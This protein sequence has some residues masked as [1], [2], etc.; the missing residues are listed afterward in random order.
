MPR[1]TSLAR[2]LSVAS[3]LGTAALVVTLLTVPVASAAPTD[4]VDHHGKGTILVSFRRGAPATAMA[5]ARAA[6]RGRVVRDV[7][8]IRA[9]SIEVDDV[10]AALAAYRERPDVEWVGREGEVHALDHVS[11][12]RYPQQ[13]NLQDVSGSNPGGLNWHAAFKS[14]PSLGAGVTVAVVDTGV[15]LVQRAAV[16]GQVV[17]TR[18]TPPDGF[19]SRKLPGYDVL[20]PSTPPDDENGHG[21]HIA[22]TIAQETGNA[23]SVGG[24]SM[25]GVAPSARILPIRVLNQEGSGSPAAAADGI[26]RAVDL[27]AKVVNLSLGGN[28]AKPLCDAVRFAVDRGVVVV[29]ASGN[30]SGAGMIPVSYP[31][32]CPGAVAV[33]GHQ[34]NAQRAEYSNGSCELAVTAPGGDITDDRNAGTSQPLADAR[35]GILQE[36]FASGGTPTYGP[37]HDSGTSMAAGHA[38]GAAAALMG[39][40][41]NKTATQTIEILRKTARDLGAPGQDSEYGAGAIDLAAAVN[42]AASNSVPAQADRLGYWTVASDGGIFSFGDAGFHGSTGDITLNSPIVGMARTPT[43]R[44]YWMVAAD[45]G[46]FNFGDAPYLGSAGNLR[47]RA[48]IVGMAATPTGRGYWL[49]ATDGGIFNYGDA[50]FM[51]STGAIRLNKPIV[52]M[53]PTRDV[54]LTDAGPRATGYWLV[55][56]DGGIFS[57]GGAQF[58]GSAGAIRLNQPIVGIAR[59]P[60]GAGYWL[61]AT[62]GGI[63]SYGDAAGLFHGSTGSIPLNKPIIGMIPTCYGQGY[64]LVASDGGIFPV[65]AVP[66][67]GSTGGITLNRPIVGATL[68]VDQRISQR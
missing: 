50:A 39:A 45:G 1:S 10:A 40:P 23:T 15:G 18:P 33:G 43:G 26:V 48:P 57:F 38:A 14:N 46:I 66:F 21:T 35:N 13:W 19:G 54:F 64:W 47:L 28:Y 8:A 6:V 25:A 7:K 17:E 61:V 32:A 53:A 4:P 16:G 41:Y 3:L 51:G 31:G 20:D 12:N 5:A 36:S 62:D 59:T 9:Q 42:A 56:S 34:W 37:Y 49:V 63:F 58:Y 2:R 30:E 68:A 27:G 55:A 29:A 44:G 52:G 60:T 22:G 24:Y 67:L 65:G 11:D